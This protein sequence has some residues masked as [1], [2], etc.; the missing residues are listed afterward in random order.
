[1]ADGEA[2]FVRGV[3]S[4]E[5]ADHGAGAVFSTAGLVLLGAV[6]AV[7][8]GELA[9]DGVPPDGQAGSEVLALGVYGVLAGAD[10]NVVVVESSFEVTASALFSFDSFHLDVD[11]ER[12]TAVG[13][14]ITSHSLAECTRLR[15][16]D[17]RGALC[18]GVSLGISLSLPFCGLV[19]GYLIGR[20]CIH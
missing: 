19:G 15:L 20:P 7:L 11:A 6:E 16:A 12:R 5:A 13:V 3:E 17:E 14:R 4:A 18:V 9:H 2:L 10:G 8:A 1:L